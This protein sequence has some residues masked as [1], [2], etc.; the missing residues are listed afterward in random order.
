MVDRFFV[1]AALRIDLGSVR[2]RATLR[3]ALPVTVLVRPLDVRGVALVAAK[4]RFFLGVVVPVTLSESVPVI[5]G[6]VVPVTPLWMVVSVTL[7][8]S[9]V[10]VTL[11]GCAVPGTLGTVPGVRGCAL[12]EIGLFPSGNS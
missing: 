4:L 6:W 8:F 7:L 5:P 1:G 11:P 3:A 10:S 9:A 2:R 12:P